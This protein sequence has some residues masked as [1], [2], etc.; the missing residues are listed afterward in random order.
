MFLIMQE[1][2]VYATNLEKMSHLRCLQIVKS[3]THERTIKRKETAMATSTEAHRPA[4]ALLGISH[5]TLYWSDTRVF[6]MSKY[7][8]PN[9]AFVTVSLLD[10]HHFML[11]LSFDLLPSQMDAISKADEKQTECTVKYF[12][13]F[14]LLT[15]SSFFT[16]CPD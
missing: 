10:D 13:S 12:A 6:L 2:L 16:P 8:I 4:F 5:Y 1:M 14:L 9:V 11:C 3:N 7:V 15:E